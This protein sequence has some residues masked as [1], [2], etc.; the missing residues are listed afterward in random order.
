MVRDKNIHKVHQ[1]LLDGDSVP[2]LVARHVCHVFR[3]SVEYEP[4]YISFN[5]SI[6]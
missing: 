4:F 2:E 1:V 3:G 6:Y 5:I